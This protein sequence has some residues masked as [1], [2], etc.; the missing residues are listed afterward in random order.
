MKKLEI[1]FVSGEGGFSVEPLTYKQL[2]RNDN[3]AVYTRSRN[4]K[5]KDYEVFRIRILKEGTNIY[6]KVT[7]EDSEQYAVTSSWGRLAW[8]FGNKTSAL[9]KF[10]ELT[11]EFVPDDESAPK[12]RGR[13]KV[14]RPDLVIPKDKAFTMV[15]LESANANTNWNKSMIYI[16]IQ[17]QIA[18]G[19]LKE[20]G[21]VEKAD[22]QRGKPA[23]L[24]SVV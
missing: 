21:I 13:A 7:T 20:A 24:Y 4:G 1:E 19:K 23:K 18:D 15:D 12:T 5:I 11:N 8:S 9:N 3:F 17:K 14:E 2:I 16:E 6:G 22:G 10:E